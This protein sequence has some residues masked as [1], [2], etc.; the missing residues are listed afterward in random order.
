MSYQKALKTARGGPRAKK[1]AALKLDVDG[2]LAVSEA[3]AEAAITGFLLAEGWLVL[4]TKAE[5]RMPSGAPA[6]KRATLDLVALRPQREWCQWTSASGFCH[7]C[8]AIVIEAKRRNARTERKHLAEQ[9][10]MAAWLRGRGFTVYQAPEGHLG[11][12]L[13]HFK[14]WYRGQGF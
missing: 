3:Q 5:A 1:A 14:G 10:A 9:T 8:D 4:Q 7:V 12:M 11:D 2:K 6:H 13:E